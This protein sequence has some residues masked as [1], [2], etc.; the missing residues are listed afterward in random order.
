MF[1]LS[2]SSHIVLL[3]LSPLIPVNLGKTSLPYSRCFFGHGHC[4][5]FSMHCHA[6][7]FSPLFL[8]LNPCI[9]QVKP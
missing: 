3:S 7:P 1:S 6:H 9:F 8:S 2:L 4:F 5:P